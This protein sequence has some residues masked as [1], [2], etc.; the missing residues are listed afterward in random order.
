[1]ESG[2]GRGVY[3]AVGYFVARLGPRRERC[4]T[5]GR[6]GSDRKR[7]AAGRQRRR[8]PPP[9][10]RPPAPVPAVERAAGA[11]G[12]ATRAEKL[13]AVSAE[14]ARCGTEKPVEGQGLDRG[15]G[16]TEGLAEARSGRPPAGRG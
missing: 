14:A 10:H 13:A 9:G 6:G 5:D 8:T 16:R 2:L 12:D 1:V 11:A 15:Y 7:E 3:G 4:G